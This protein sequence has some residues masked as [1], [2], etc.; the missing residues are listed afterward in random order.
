VGWGLQDGV[1]DGAYFLA[2]DFFLETHHSDK[3]FAHYAHWTLTELSAALD[4][5]LEGF[6]PKPLTWAAAQPTHFQAGF[7]K[8]TPLFRSGAL[9][10]AVPVIFDHAAW[11][12]GFAPEK[13]KAAWILRAIRYAAVAPV[14]LYGF[15]DEAQGIVG[16]TPEILIRSEEN[17]RWATMALA[18]TRRDAERGSRPSLMDDPKERREHELVID[19]ISKSLGKFGKLRVGVTQEIRLPGLA[20]LK[21]E[22][23]VETNG[24]TL[25]EIVQALHPTPALG[26]FPRENGLKLL[27]SLDEATGVKRARFGAPFGFSNSDFSLALVAIRN[28]QWNRDGIFLGAG[29]GII[30]ESE[31]EREWLELQA[32]IS[33]VKRIFGV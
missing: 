27:R 11:P 12:T 6:D 22:I 13:F 18:G 23:S 25:H 32:K 29:C 8:L 9:Q 20:H 21:T 15:W 7:E 3:Y 33:S 28:L 31:P 16:A 1:T 5:Y 30:A 17:G 4:R 2:P 24:A 10:K 26:T 19:G 14:S